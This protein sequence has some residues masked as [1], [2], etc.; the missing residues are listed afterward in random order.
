MRRRD[1][2]LLVRVD[3]EDRLPLESLALFDEIIRETAAK[4]KA[5]GDLEDTPEKQ[6]ASGMGI[7]YEKVSTALVK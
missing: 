1:R 2:A 7:D 5:L 4:L 6:M 3:A